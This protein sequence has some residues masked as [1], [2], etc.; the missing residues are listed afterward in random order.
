MRLHFLA[1]SLPLI[2]SLPVFAQWGWG[3]EQLNQGTTLSSNT[4]GNQGDYHVE[5]WK[6][7][8]NESGSMTLDED[9][10]FRCN[11]N[12]NENILFRKGKRPGSRDLVVV[13]EA[14]FNPQ[15]NAY[16]SI[17]GWFQNPLVEY[18]I[19]ESWGNYRPPGAA[20]KGGFE[21]EEG[22]YDLYQTE[23]TGPSIEGD[24]KTFQQYW[25]VRTA[26]KTKGSVTVSDHFD[27][28][29]NVGFQIGSIYEVSFNVEAY[30]SDGGSADVKMQIMTKSE[31]E[32]YLKTGVDKRSRFNRSGTVTVPML[33]GHTPAT[34]YNTL[35]Q[36]ITGMSGRVQLRGPSSV[37][38]NTL[39]GA[40]GV[41]YS[42]PD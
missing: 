40:S 39:N 19:I 38:L 21:T 1:V 18:Y 7:N 37:Q 14:D 12:Y 22:K 35:G 34:F 31:Y 3:T 26:R 17:Y 16:L 8:D 29:Q 32:E 27:G 42:I 15:G 28:W 30:K 11:W 2:F 23:R 5:Y 4:S 9:G 6:Q 36:K 41:Y 20:K 24:N 33:N 25:S 13:Y 10:G